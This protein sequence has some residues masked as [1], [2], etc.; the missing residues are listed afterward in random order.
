M[1]Q[2]GADVDA[3]EALSRTFDH[4]SRRLFGSVTVI[5]STMRSVW[6]AGIG[7]ARFETEWQRNHA[8]A[9][10]SVAQL[11]AEAARTVAA[12]SRQ[13][14]ATSTD[15][16]V[17]ANLFTGGFGAAL[18]AIRTFA[19]HEYST[20][21]SFESSHG[22]L[23]ADGSI[24]SNR[25][26]ASGSVDVLTGTVFATGAASFGLLGADASGAVGARADL[27]RLQGEAHASQGSDALGLSE[28]GSLDAAIDARADADGAVHAGLDG[29]S[30]NGS[31]GAFVGAEATAKGSVAAHLGRFTMRASGEA[32]AAYGAGAEASGTFS[33]T[34][35]HIT[36][37]GKLGAVFGGGAE[38][39]G[40]I[41]IGF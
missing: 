5:D 16:K 40:K 11:L 6:W 15:Q 41:E 24:G 27:L 8:A 4:E 32:S 17:P 21:A 33:I 34:R 2:L 25:T 3:L 12:Q 35:H 23:R 1:Q 18:D 13:Q 7:A 9:V 19:L 37:G 20:S 14:R 10:R 26:G 29:V 39:G 31:A 22:V 38:A 36:L 30:A 28:G